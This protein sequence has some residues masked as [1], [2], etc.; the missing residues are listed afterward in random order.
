VGFDVRFRF[1]K[2][3][4]I[5]L[6]T[7]NNSNAVIACMLFAYAFGMLFWICVPPQADADDKAGGQ[8]KE[9]APEDGILC[10]NGLV[11]FLFSGNQ[12]LTTTGRAGIFRSPSRGEHWQRSMEGFVASNGV[13]PSVNHVCQS[14]SQP[15]MIYALAGT[16][17][18]LSPFN[19]LFF[20][21][22]FGATWTRRGT[23]NTGGGVNFCT[24]DAGDP[25]MVY[26]SGFDDTDFS[27][28]TW[29][30]T[31]GGQTINALTNLP[32]CA[33]GGLVYSVPRAL[34]L[35]N[36]IQC[37]YSSTDGGSTF[38]QL[39]TPPGTY[40][41]L[42]VRPDGHAIFVATYDANFQPTGAF[43]STDGGA[44]F[45]A[46]SGLPSGFVDLAFDPTNSSRVYANDDD[47]LLRAS[48]DE[49]LTFTLSPASNDPRLLGPRPVLQI[50]VDRH[51]S[52]Y[53]D[54]LAGPFRTDD[55]GQT[56]RSASNGFRASAVNDLAFDASGKLLVGVL[57]TQVVFRETQGLKFEPI[58]NTPAIDINGFNNDATALGASPTDPNVILVAMSSGQG[59]L[60]TENGGQ[61][62]TSSV[63]QDSPNSFT[64][65]RM[66]FPTS[67]RVYLVSRVPRQSKPG[68]Y[69]SDDAG[70][71]FAHL[72]TLRFGAIAVDPTNA[73]T[74]YAGTYFS[75][76]GLFKST[77]GGQTLEDLGQPGSYSAIAVDR[78]NS[79]IVYVGQLFGQV[80]RSLDA[81]QTFS[82]ASTGLT[83]A[84]V[85]AIAQDSRGTLFVWVRGGGL[86][87][88][89]DGASSWQRVDSDE[90]LRRSG[91]EVGR[92]SLVVDPQVPGRV[93]LGHAG[94]IQINAD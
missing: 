53:A 7:R 14:P 56:F 10:C 22:D 37:T 72:S 59:L 9:A 75:S 78:R 69:R 27:R 1:D 41:F 24:V 94:V 36:G 57:H 21:D 55:G 68:L 15:R 82:S 77:D 19:G 84:G 54:T 74:I 38:H 86:F 18:D 32:D 33:V 64:N 81:G 40:G 76:E 26:V 63:L 3:E 47:G 50:G 8:V 35:F 34:Y 89:H 73:D 31:D 45:V 61:S 16:G 79:Q 80:I 11:P 25:R 12:V 83:G 51:G 39:A 20:S 52:V 44:S 43:R 71:T 93:Y 58:G 5:A 88:S 17:T 48:T 30:S 29:K 46:V 4:A 62:W 85:H 92:G 42:Q 49:G 66:A 91:V 13:S 90:A 2:K 70:R 67:S 87:A 6:K 28:K 65:A 60:R 23:V